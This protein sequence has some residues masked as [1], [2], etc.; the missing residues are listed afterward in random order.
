MTNSDETKDKFYEDLG[1]LV[2][3]FPKEDKFLV[4]SD[5]SVRVETDHKTWEGSIRSN[6]VGNSNSNG[7]LLL[8]TCSAHDLLIT[9]TI[10]RLPNRNTISW[11]HPRSNHWH[12]N[13]S[14]SR[15]STSL[16]SRNDVCKE[17][18][19]ARNLMSQ[20]LNDPLYIKSSEM[21][22]MQTLKV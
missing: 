6:G 7:H 2:N 17:R 22:S 15:N 4:L 1:S 16:S 10:F 8:G 18:S 9:N 14:S 3:S 20:S 13:D 12:L 21:T 11:M 19:S 5:F